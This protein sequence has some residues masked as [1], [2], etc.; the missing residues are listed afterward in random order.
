M[1]HE[2][3]AFTR[4]GMTYGERNTREERVELLCGPPIALLSVVAIGVVWARR[5][6]A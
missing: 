3:G 4:P 1:A 2:P 5:H 6:A